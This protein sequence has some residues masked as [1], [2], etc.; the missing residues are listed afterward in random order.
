MGSET[1]DGGPPRLHVAAHGTDV[2]ESVQILRFSKADGGCSIL[3]DREPDALD[4]AWSGVDGGFRDDAV[5]YVRLRQRGHI[6]SRTV[7]AWSSPVWVT[8]RR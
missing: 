5:Y 1:I 6:R 8:R 4:F 2:I 7:M 3:F